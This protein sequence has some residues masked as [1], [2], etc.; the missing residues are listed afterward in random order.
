MSSFTAAKKQL[1]VWGKSVQQ[2]FR[3][4]ANLLAPARA[5]LSA[6]IKHPATMIVAGMVAA[7]T[8]FLLL[9]QGRV[10]S[11]LFL[12]AVGLLV[13]SFTSNMTVVF[14]ATLGVFYTYLL[15]RP[16]WWWGGGGGTGIKEGLTA[17]ATPPAD[18]KAD[19]ATKA[20]ATTKT[21]APVAEEQVIEQA[22]PTLAQQKL[23]LIQ[24]RVDRIQTD[25]DTLRPTVDSSTST[26]TPV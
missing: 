13:A 5:A 24:T 19:D 11:L 9:L 7:Y 14:L 21:P 10:V 17:A 25:L 12:C 22:E 6:T 16:S 8:A 18:E 1:S 26:T 15:L 23:E 4:T 20:T 2:T 3:P